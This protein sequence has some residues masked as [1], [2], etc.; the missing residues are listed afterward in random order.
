MAKMFFLS[1][2]T[3]DGHTVKQ[4]AESLG[5]D[6]CW[7]YE[8]EIK[9][10]D[11]IFEFDRGIADSRIFVVFWS[12]NSA[13][14]PWVGEEISQ[15]RIKISR[16]R[17]FR[18]VVVTLDDEPLPPSLAHRSYINGTGRVQDIT[19]ALLRLRSELT[20]EDTYGG[21][22]ILRDSFQNRQKELDLLE[23]LA[24]SGNSPVL[25]TG[26]DGMGKTSLMKRATSAI[27][28]HLTPMWVDLEVS[29]TPIRLISAIAKPLSIQIDPHDAATRAAQVW[30]S[31]LL[32]EIKDS[33]RL[34]L[35][36]DNLQTQSSGRYV[37]NDIT[38]RLVET[39]CRDLL[40]THKPK[41]PGVVLISRE[42]PPFGQETLSRFKR[43][44][45]GSLDNKS[46]A[47]A[48]R[49]YLSNLSSLDYDLDKLET[50][51]AHIGG[52][53]AAI[54]ALSHRVARQG[55]DAV[56]ADRT[57][58]RRI[59]YSIGESLFSHVP[60][61]QEEQDLLI[62]IATS[63]YPLTDYHLNSIMK[64][65]SNIMDSIKR[66]QFLDPTSQGYALHGILRDYVSESMANPSKIIECHHKLAQLFD[67]EWRSALALSAERAEYGSLCYF[68]TL[69]SGSRRSAK[70]IGEDYLEETKMAAVEL[71]RRGQYKT[72]VTYLSAAKKIND[73]SDPI[74][75]FYYALCLNRLEQP[76][77]ALKVIRELVRKFPHIARYNHAH[78]TI[79]RSIGDTD[80]A[81]QAWRM[82][83][84]L[85]VGRGKVAPLCS[86]SELLTTLERGEE[87]L[88][89]VEEALSLD[90][91][92]SFVVATASLVYG[93]LGQTDKALGII[94]DGLRISPGNARLHHRAGIILRK[95]GLISE[96]V[97][98]LEKA[99]RDPIYGFS[100]T[101]LADAYL[102][103]G[104]DDK[105]EEAVE[106]FSG[107]KT[108][109]TSYL[110]TKANIL[111]KRGDYPGAEL[112]LRK[113][114]KIQPNNVVLYGG[115]AQVKLDEAHNCIKNGEKQS[116][117]IALNTA[118][119][120]IS[121]GLSLETGETLLS[122]QYE[123]DKFELQI[124]H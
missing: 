91:G 68:H 104:E 77:E 118:K 66:K 123:I 63:A 98:H 70:L 51:V 14:S 28:S 67:R 42:E 21:K 90:P 37:G 2:S 88:P 80:G 95:M 101:A 10:G 18:L 1:H 93:S 109:N 120:F 111:R 89:L 81:M 54:I 39:I 22:P 121:K 26:L 31:M 107:N 100:I 7:L 97:E 87:A 12:T 83:A 78:G 61:S 48:L 24:F 17:G 6:Q 112:L 38:L 105:A 11:S 44:Q 82:A 29:S 114:I 69:S 4:I 15:A 96:A 20:P 59:R 99:S 8:W 84:S 52:Y 40:E 72:A 110:S 13:N 79:L 65:N 122:I 64:Q 19:K 58:L 119:T 92:D 102:D 9:P 106:R 53:P 117:L 33:Q 5:R 73:I 32:P 30:Q 34:F 60:I 23:N 16:D 124:G 35:I 36:L 86:L 47:R 3:E 49:F 94:R 46:I 45:I 41:N 43:L 25:I 76:E 62:L 71:Y 115:M 57:E 75:D 108:R 50:L 74:C 27:F 113:A 55:V 85:A 116:A 56:L 103:L